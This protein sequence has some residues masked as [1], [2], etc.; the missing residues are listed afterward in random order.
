MH[1]KLIGGGGRRKRANRSRNIFDVSGHDVGEKG[2][3]QP[4]KGGK[5][6]H[7]WWKPGNGKTGERKEARR[8]IIMT[9]NSLEKKLLGAGSGPQHIKEGHG[10]SAARKKR[11]ITRS[12][13]A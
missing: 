12:E 1:F 2:K 6:S 5:R 11:V 10:E 3:K 8:I 13:N 4:G 9:R 7:G